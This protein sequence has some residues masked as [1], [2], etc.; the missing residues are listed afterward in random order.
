MTK[1]QTL[2]LASVVWFFIWIP[3]GGYWGLNPVRWV[4]GQM[5]G[6]GGHALYVDEVSHAFPVHLASLPPSTMSRHNQQL[7]N[8][9]ADADPLFDPEDWALR[10]MR[11]RWCVCFFL[12]VISGI[13]MRCFL[14]A[15]VQ[16][17]ATWAD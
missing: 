9:D 2:F 3:V 15:I 11:Y 8:E 5:H 10:E 16:G 12:F 1:R 6:L 7:D 4:E 17:K 13:C 14:S